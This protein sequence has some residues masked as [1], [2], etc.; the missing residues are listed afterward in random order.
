MNTNFKFEKLDKLN[1]DLTSN[2]ETNLE[3]DY[4]HDYNQSELE[5]EENIR[6]IIHLCKQKYPDLKYKITK[7]VKTVFKEKFRVSYKK[8]EEKIRL[9]KETI[10]HK[11]THSNSSHSSSKSITN[12]TNQSVNETSRASNHIF[13]PQELTT[14]NNK[15]IDSNQIKLLNS[16]SPSQSN[17]FKHSINNHLTSDLKPLKKFKSSTNT[18]QS[19][20]ITT[21]SDA[22]NDDYNGKLNNKVIY[23]T[24]L[25]LFVM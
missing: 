4:D 23:F 16:S 5:N 19:G 10:D 13:K 25:W 6:K 8:T 15:N 20:A 21:T 24:I 1:P 18:S 9:I 11:F 17:S 14:K 2:Q 12:K 3:M 7:C 22:K